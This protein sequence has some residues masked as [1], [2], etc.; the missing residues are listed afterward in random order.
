MRR[1]IFLGFLVLSLTSFAAMEIER[2]Y[3]DIEFG[4]SYYNIQEK[5]KEVNPYR[6]LHNYINIQNDFILKQGSL[7]NWDK[8]NVFRIYATGANSYKY[9]NNGGGILYYHSYTDGGFVG[10]QLE[11]R[12]IKFKLDKE[13]LKGT[14][15]TIRFIFD[16]QTEE[17]DRLLFTPYY[18]FDN[19][20]EI[21]NKAIGLYFRQEFALDLEKYGLVQDGIK[22]FVDLDTHRD[23][24]KK[25]K[26]IDSKKKTKNK[27]DSLKVGLGALYNTEIDTNSGVKIK[28]EVSISYDKE[29]LEDR[30]YK[31]VGIKEK[32]IDVAKIGIGLSFE[33][34]NVE[35]GIENTYLKSLN[36]SNYENRVTGQIIYKF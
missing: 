36:T 32:D 3:G 22:V 18:T 23:N 16:K 35:I 1:K 27:N 7:L 17:G 19:I 29:F 26:N 24:V 11:A 6:E 10:V 8:E 25:Q 20:K 2:G 21:K 30:K 15:G 13:D 33:Y 34:K 9:N 31:A 28:P 5:K 4:A 14:R 12:K